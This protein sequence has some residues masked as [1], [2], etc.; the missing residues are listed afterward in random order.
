MSIIINGENYGDM[1]K[2][3]TMKKEGILVNNRYVYGRS[4][5]TLQTTGGELVTFNTFNDYISAF[6]FKNKTGQ[7]IGVDA[8]GKLTFSDFQYMG[9]EPSTVVSQDVLLEVT[10]STSPNGDIG[11]DTYQQL[12]PYKWYQLEIFGAGGGGGGG[13]FLTD[14]DAFIMENPIVS[15]PTDGGAGGY[16]KS[17]FYVT[18]PGQITVAAGNGGGGGGG[19]S[20]VKEGLIPIYRLWN[21]PYGGD[22]GRGYKFLETAEWEYVRSGQDSKYERDVLELK[23]EGGIYD[24]TTCAGGSSISRATIK[25]RA[26]ITG[27]GGGSSNGLYGGCGG[28]FI[29]YHHVYSEGP[30]VHACGG[31]GG[32][33]GAGSCG[34]NN[35][36]NHSGDVHNNSAGHG[37]KREGGVTV[38]TSTGGTVFITEQVDGGHGYYGGGGGAG[39]LMR[40]SGGNVVIGEWSHCSGG[41]G[42]GGGNAGAII[43]T[44]GTVVWKKI[45]S[46]IRNDKI[47]YCGGGGGGAGGGTVIEQCDSTS[48]GAGGNS[49][50]I[51]I[52]ANGS[53]GG[54]GGTSYFYRKS[55]LDEDGITEKMRGKN[56]A[57]GK[58]ILREHIAPSTVYTQ[59]L[60]KPIPRPGGGYT[61]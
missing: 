25:Y 10:G 30:A 49:M 6:K 41:G 60:P 56:G 35:F 11:I 45:G 37:G 44:T 58:V 34:Y 36:Y 51:Y 52:P 24:N 2:M 46:E 15:N 1:N 33:A 4:L 23:S 31:G 55:K 43:N 42:G 7:F 59:P 38:P 18:R 3:S 48:G 12:E 21:R 50:G 47:V 57:P 20:A 29:G 40:D 13:A 5:K 61:V 32:G 26:F 28:Q 17:S 53:A 8:D 9:D 54:A 19:T 39:V 16:F 22:G 27:G 14:N